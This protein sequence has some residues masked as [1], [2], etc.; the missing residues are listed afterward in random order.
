MSCRERCTGG[1]YGGHHPM[2][3]DARECIMCE[4]PVEE[5]HLVCSACIEKDE[6]GEIDRIDPYLLEPWDK[7]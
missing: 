6:A 5:D 3:P 2:C 7:D 4:G 1:S